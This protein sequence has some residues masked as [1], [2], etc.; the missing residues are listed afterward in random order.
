MAAAAWMAGMGLAGDTARAADLFVRIQGDQFALNGQVYKIKGTNYYPRDHMWADMWSNFNVGRITSDAQLMH[1]LGL[2]AVRILV[3]YSKGGWDGPT[4]SRGKLDQLEQVVN[5]MGAQGLRSVVTLFDW[6]TSFPAAGSGTETAHK[7]YVNLI[8]DRLKTNPYVLLWDVK[9]EPDHPSN[10]GSCDCN[11]GACG[12]WDCNPAKRDQIVSWLGRMC[13]AV[14]SRDPNHP[15]SA[16]MR[17]WQNLPDVL[18]FMD[19]AIFHSYW[20]NISS[21]E[22]P[23]TKSYM[24]SNQKPILVEEWGWPTNP[25]PCYRDGRYIY[26]YNENQQLSL[27]Q[28]HLAAFQQHNIAGGLQ[29]M[30]F[31]SRSYANDPSQSFEQYFGLW[32]Y[33]YTLKPAGIYYR[34][35]FP[36]VPFPAIPLATG[37]LNSFAATVTGTQIGLSWSNPSTVSFAGT[38]VR[39]STEGFPATPDA[40]LLMCDRPASPGSVDFFVHTAPIVGVTY[41][42]AAFPYNYELAFGPGSDAAQTVVYRVDFDGDGDVDMGDFGRMQMCLSGDF[43]PQPDPLCIHAR[44]DGD[45]DVDQ[46]DLSLF[47]T[48]LQPTGGGLQP[49]CGH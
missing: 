12:N 16:G 40:G 4:T 28:S 8:A 31:D 41:Y 15:A 35:N 22:I 49:G 32:K 9:N 6:E 46:A 7:T 20:P 23:Q 37:P 47:R 24:G 45:T 14:R 34:D 30:T 10:Y 21:E 29:W 44:I 33:D 13:N 36:V 18:G 43:I 2:N 19:V 39:Y 26:D 3:P 11:P 1:D 48:C 38:M 25:T 42:Y 27:Y 5:I 17:W